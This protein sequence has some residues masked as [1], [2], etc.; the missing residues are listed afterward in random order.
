MTV[1]REYCQGYL[2]YR[3][4]DRVTGFKGTITSMSFDLYGCVQAAITADI[5]IEEK[6]GKQ[7][8]GASHWFDCNRLELQTDERII[9]LPEFPFVAPS[10]NEPSAA[11]VRSDYT[12][13][14]NS[15][16]A[17]R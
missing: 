12:G 8:F 11:K 13:P 5:V 1:E 14:D 10:R 4:R 3:A 16:P 7:E 9:P 17:P 2:G 15:K 6:T